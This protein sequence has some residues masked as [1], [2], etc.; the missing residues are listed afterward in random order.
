MIGRSHLLIEINSI[1]YLPEDC[2]W[3]NATGG[4]EAGV[5]AVCNGEGSVLVA[6]PRASVRIARA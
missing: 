5:C 2:A 6:Q 1:T 4:S 3:C